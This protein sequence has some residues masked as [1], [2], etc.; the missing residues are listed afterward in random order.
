MIDKPVPSLLATLLE[1]L[2]GR[3]DLELEFKRA[4]GGLPKDLWP[5]VSAFANTRGGWVV[6]GIGEHEDELSLEGVTNTSALLKSF[7]DLIRNPQKISQPV[8]GANDTSIEPLGEGKRVVVIRVPAAPRK[9]RPV[10]VNGNPYDGTFV[11]RHSGDY[12]CT[13]PEVDRM[14]REASDASADSTVLERF[15]LDDIDPMTLARYRRRYQ[16][17]NPSSPWNGYDD[18]RFLQALGAF[19]RDRERGCEGITVAGLLLMGTPEALRE[20]RTRHM[21]DYRLVRGEADAS[22]GWDDRVPWEGNL[23]SAFEVIYPRLT[24]GQPIPFRLEGGIR[25]DQSPVHVAL[26]EALVNLLVHADYSETQAS[27]IIRAASGY[28][29]R[30]PGNSRVLESDLLTGDRSDPRN[31][32]LVRMFR[33]I[34]LAEEAGTGIPRI[35]KAWRELGFQLPEL[36]VGTERYE[37]SLTLRHAHLLSDDDRVWLHSPGDNWSEAEQLALVIA[38]HP[39]E[40]DNLSVRRLT[41]QH[42]A[43]VTRVLGGLRDRGFLQMIGVKRG[44]RY[45]LGAATHAASPDTPGPSPDTLTP[46]PDTLT[47]SIDTS[48]RDAPGLWVELL[49]LARP[50]REHRRLDVPTRDAIILALCT[51]TPLSVDELTEL[52]Q[53]GEAIVRRTIQSLIARQQLV[54]RYPE[55]PSHPRQRYRASQLPLPQRAD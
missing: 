25:L 14:M 36:D 6:L 49:E 10:Y 17:L 1:R 3:E 41:G 11:R 30:N 37:F 27:L 16:T 43:D 38:R 40:V 28:L 19:R 47:P 51:R 32:E 34:G 23:F 26:R 46:S 55:Q 20:W 24:E 12:H 13:K 53:R 5:T 21:I 39:G 35:I 18:Y 45:Q 54:Y 31:P 33:L 8:C 15:D 2:Q 48:P 52:L 22:E 44:A 7:H 9:A 29:F 42:M 4:R 50:A